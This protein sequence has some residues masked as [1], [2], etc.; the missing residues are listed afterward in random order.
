MLAVIAA[1]FK[2]TF[3]AAAAALARSF[4]KACILPLAAALSG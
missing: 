4:A 2:A 1:L 3:V